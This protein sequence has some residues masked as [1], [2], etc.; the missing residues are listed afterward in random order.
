[1]TQRVNSNRIANNA[2]TAPKLFGG[3][4]STDLIAD[5]AVTAVKIADSAV[6]EIKIATGAVTSAKVQSGLLIPSGTV[7][8]F[9][10]TAAP[11]GWTKSVTHNDKALRIVSGSVSS[12]GNTAFSSTFVNRTPA[13]SVSGTN[14]GGAVS[15]AGLTEAQLPS[16]AHTE[17][18]MSSVA[19]M[20]TTGTRIGGSGS[21]TTNRTATSPT[22]GT[23]SGS[24][25][26]H[27]FTQPSWSGSFTGTALDFGV[28][29][30]DAIIA[31][32]D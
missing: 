25:H 4:V 5:S 32:K 26:G 14:S 24:V 20:T 16:H 3:G 29:Y 21:G 28:Q 22:L 2:I 13:G 17:Q 30:V 27:G 11:T 15:D 8:L 7:M 23:G 31:T 18:L 10:Q 12:G 9:V 1:M 19:T 6:T